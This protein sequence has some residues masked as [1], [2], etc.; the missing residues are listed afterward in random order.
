MHS[1]SVKPRRNSVCSPWDDGKVVQSERPPAVHMMSGN[2]AR[3]ARLIRPFDDEGTHFTFTKETTAD[4]RPKMAAKKGD[5]EDL[6]TIL[7]T[8]APA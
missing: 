2:R 8:S 7:S 5:H 4:K 3:Q 1:C 6:L